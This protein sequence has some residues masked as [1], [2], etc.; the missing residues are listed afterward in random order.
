MS[1]VAYEQWLARK[2]LVVQPVGFEP[3]AVNAEL[4]P[5][6]ADLVRWALRRGRAALF[7]DTGLGKTLMQLGWAREIHEHS[8][9]DVLLLCPLAVSAQTVDEAAR[10]GI[11]A[12]LCRTESDWRPGLNVT[13]YDRLHRFVDRVPSL[14]GIVLDESSCLKDFTSATRTELINRFRSTPYRLACS[15]TPSPND[16]TE[17]GNHAE[18]LGAMTRAEMLAS[19]FINDGEKSN[20]WRLKRHATRDFWRWVSSWAALARKPSDL[21]YDDGA[22]ELPAL[23]TRDVEI[24]ATAEAA[25]AQG[26]LFCEPAASLLEQRQARRATLDE[27]CEAVAKLVATEPDEQWLVW[28]ELNDESAALAK[29]IPGAVEVVGSDSADSKESALLGFARGEHRIMVTK[30]SIAGHGM[31]W[32]RCARMVFVGLSHSFEQFYQ[33]VRRCWRFGQTRPVHVY[34]VAHELEG[35]VVESVR[36]KHADAERMG[37]ELAAMVGAHVRLAVIGAARTVDGYEAHETMVVPSW[38]RGGEQCAA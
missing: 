33:A 16:Y 4:F 10:F 21:G 9:R 8:G 3:G 25:R 15:A 36:R 28:C 12:T 38:I 35:N 37:A 13:N 20:E 6:Q 32:Q 2:R 22:F 27:R 17:L 1:A 30:P 34:I 7:A 23:V 5:F 18:F 29:L 19:F 31:N 24:A 11:A 14:S 26:R